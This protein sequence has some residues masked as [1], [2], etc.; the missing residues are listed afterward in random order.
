[1]AS[2][3]G[4]TRNATVVHWPN[5]VKAAGGICH[6]FH[7]VIDVAPTVLEAADL[8]M[9]L[10][11]NGVMQEPMH[12]VSM[13]YTFGDI[14]AAERHETQYFEM[15]GNRGIYHKGWT[16]VTRHRI[17]WITTGEIGIA[18]DDDVWEL[19][20][21][22]DW[23]QTRDLSKE[24]PD[25]LSEL[26]RLFLIE[27]T[28]YH[29]LP[30]DDRFGERGNPDI[31]GRPV[32]VRGNKQLLFAGM[33]HLNEFNLLNLKNKSF[34]VTAQ[35]VIPEGGAN[36]VILNMGGGIG[37]WAV[38][39]K[40]GQLTYC[41]NLL[42]IQRTYVRANAPVPAGEHQLRLEF[43][44]GGGGIAKGGA[45]S[46]R[47]DGKEV[48]AGRVERTAPMG[49]TTDETTDVGRDDSSP[50]TDEYQAGNN[51]FTGTIKWVRTGDR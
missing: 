3:W 4:D 47:V 27:A 15:M 42:G 50:V 36:G 26:Q 32:L 7:H 48:A 12:G 20:D 6:Q 28:K 19:Y 1:V 9:P 49:F 39:L 45:V 31:T 41:C 17:P 37:G 8:P 43:N 11:V 10:M 22:S 24:M 46:L 18:F 34:T 51:A 40:E 2:H 13:A 29:V 35:V 44:Y 30:L 5:G 21:A 25:K 38:Y 33:G 23:S 16:A 14:D